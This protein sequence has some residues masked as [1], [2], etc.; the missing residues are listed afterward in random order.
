MVRK[1]IQVGSKEIRRF[2]LLGL[3]VEALWLLILV[4]ACHLGWPANS[5]SF[6]LGGLIFLIPNTYFAFY[7]FR[8]SGAL[9]T[10]WIVRSLLTGEMG[11]LALSAVAF[12]IVFNVHKDV[13][14]EVLFSGFL[15]MVLSHIVVAH[16]LSNRLTH[17]ANSD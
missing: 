17:R 9:Q 6:L 10:P 3:V 12:G 5:K 11:K 16:V 1:V 15:A 4:A 2:V 14:A 7:A 13:Q 8:Y